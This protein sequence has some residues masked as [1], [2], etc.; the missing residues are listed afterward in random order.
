MGRCRSLNIRCRAHL[1]LASAL[2]SLL[3]LSITMAGDLNLSLP[4]YRLQ[5]DELAVVVNERD[6]L[7][8]R[9]GEY[10]IQA[11]GL[12]QE[13]LLHLTFD[14]I[15][16]SLPVPAFNSL[17]KALLKKT[18]KHIQA[19]ALTWRTPY[20]VGCM[21]MT[22]AITFD[23]DK[24]WCSEHRC[25][26]TR[27]SPYFNYPGA[28][29]L[30][31]LA[32]RPSIAIAAENFATAKKLIDRGMLADNSLPQG[33]AY[34]VSTN[35]KQRNVRAIEF[36][37]IKKRM[38]GWIDTEIVR[39]NSLRHRNDVIF[40]FTGISQVD[41]LDTLTF[42]P[43]AIADHLT[44][45]G[46]QL[47]GSRQMSAMAWLKAGASGS[48]GTV[49]EPCNHR[50]KFPSPALVMEH[51]GNGS[52]LIEA[53]WKSVQQPGEGIFIGD[54]LAAPF[55]HVEIIHT[56]Q[57]SKV[58]TRNLKPGNYQLTYAVSPIGPFKTISEVIVRYHQKELKL[59]RLNEGYYRLQQLGK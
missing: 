17:R 20:R 1:R 48:Y 2:F 13:N 10:Y 29:P 25:A 6:L 55:D 14:P 47:S 33:T 32:L 15:P 36:A 44:S 51:Y 40:Y 53:Y 49:V 45:M 31:D 41:G 38:Q 56:D 19:Y 22:S 34:L 46:G 59:P 28:N 42:R 35:D 54:P 9:I 43:G 37:H 23:F 52:T 7:S 8:V 5:P 39:R 4:K 3:S 58:K 50:G 11:R 57:E 12:P 21:S 16:E 24:A 26:P 18:P 27:H 30:E